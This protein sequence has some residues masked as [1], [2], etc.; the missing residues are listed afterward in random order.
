MKSI[1]RWF[2]FCM[3]IVLLGTTEASMVLAEDD[4][5][6]EV[7][8]LE[9]SWEDPADY[10]EYEAIE[11][12]YIEEDDFTFIENEPQYQDPV[13]PE[14]QA[15]VVTEAIQQV[16]TTIYAE[17]TTMPTTEIPL[18]PAPTSA[19]MSMDDVQAMNGGNAIILTENDKV[20]FI[21]GTFYAGQVTDF[22]SAAAALQ[23]IYGLLGMSPDTVLM[24]KGAMSDSYGNIIYRFGQM[25][26]NTE[27][28][29]GMVK[30]YT[31]ASGHVTG[32]SS[33]VTG[34]VIPQEGVPVTAAEAESAVSAYLIRAG[35]TQLPIMSAYTRQMLAPNYVSD[36][37]NVPMMYMWAVYTWNPEMTLD[38]NTSDLPFLAHFVN[39]AGEYRYSIPCTLP[40]LEES[41]N[42]DA[43]FDAMVSTTWT[44]TV[45]RS[46]GSAV[47][48]TVPVMNSLTTGRY[49]LAD[50]VRKIAVA[51]AWSFLYD[52]GSLVMEE[53]EV[54]DGWDPQ[55]VLAYA[56]I[57]Q[58]Y[59][60]YKSAGFRG[61]DVTTGPI[62]ILKNFCAPDQTPA[63]KAAYVGQV[64]GW[65][66]F[67]IGAQGFFGQS[68]DLIGHAYTHYVTGI[69]GSSGL[70]QNDFG[71]VSE[72][73]CDIL[74]NVAEMQSGRST[75]T[76]WLIG[77]KTGTTIRSMSSPQVCGQPAYTGGLFYRPTVFKPNEAN[78][79]GGIQADSSLLGLV[80]Y[81]LYEGGM[82]LEQCKGYWS[83]VLS[84]INPGTTNRQL[85]VLLP[86]A[87]NRAG[88]T[89]FMSLLYGAM[90]EVLMGYD[91]WQPSQP[92]EGSALV[93]MFLPEESFLAHSEPV[94]TLTGTDG[95]AASFSSTIDPTGS[96]S[97]LVLPG[98]YEVSITVLDNGLSQMV[99]WIYDGVSWIQKDPASE[100]ATTASLT[101]SDGVT[102]QL[103]TEGLA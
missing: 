49:Y 58:A 39:S 89:E 75:D 101:L 22:S 61:A 38:G 57:I 50:P 3:V 37:G 27:I 80:A 90:D 72:A 41:T 102:V 60:F 7:D 85:T 66:A 36:Q 4:Y 30:V 78:E 5:V 92:A 64:H 13:Q 12:P 98:S 54:N 100:D 68:L 69:L 16:Q 11:D 83:T 79:W 87:L 73:V 76:T 74:G 44:G 32:M 1:T 95:Q 31:D 48:L 62:L 14:Q 65:R 25:Q 9:D 103:N 86:W 45:V 28:P 93:T 15:A 94:V 23:R 20:T 82:T 24:Q 26:N 63:K 10:V 43:A 77:E 99:T 70:N 97:L 17:P 47:E 35:L 84:A 8:D 96:L 34:Y 42:T 56:S 33:S 59:D 88:L 51:D 52:N 19:A 18:S 55:L 40:P 2:V 81:R 46:D 29:Q 21:D 67:G 53:K 71:S 6:F 91:Y